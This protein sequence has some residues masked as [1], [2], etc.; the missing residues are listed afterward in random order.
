MIGLLTNSPVSDQLVHWG[1]G[2]NEPQQPEGEVEGNAD[3]PVEGSK[4]TATTVPCSQCGAELEFKPTTQN[5]R[6]SYCGHSQHIEVSADAHV[7]EYDLNDA[8]QRYLG[9]V[10]K[11]ETQG[12]REIKCQDCGADIIVEAGQKTARCD[13]CGGRR[14]IEE[15]LPPGVLQAEGLLPF[16]FKADDAVSKFRKWL[17][18]GD[19]WF[20]KLW[21]R[22]VRPRALQQ[23]ASVEDLH[24]IYVPYWTYDSKAHA[25]WTA[26]AG[27]YYYVTRSYR[28]SQGRSRTRQ[29]RRVRWVWTSGQRRDFFDDWLVC[30]SKQFHQGK[31]QGLLQQIE[32]FPTKQ[33]V[34]YDGKYLV[35]FRA[36]R[37]SL[38][39]KQG[40][41]IARTGMQS[42]IRNRCARD[43]PGD[44]YRFLDVRTSFFG[45][46][47]KLVALPVY[48]M[49]Y[50]FNNKQFNV[51]INGSTGLVKGEAPL[52]PIKVAILIAVILLI[53]G[54]IFGLVSLAGSDSPPPQQH[55]QPSLTEPQEHQDVG[56][57]PRHQL[58]VEVYDPMTD[59]DEMWYISWRFAGATG[60]EVSANVAE[61]QRLN[62]DEA[63]RISLSMLIEEESDRSHYFIAQSIENYINRTYPR[64]GNRPRVTDTRIDRIVD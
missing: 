22:L 27:Y 16:R 33:L 31:L 52:S 57:I 60:E 7:I 17:A 44:T 41:G 43:I 63:L 9:R 37:Y 36:E 48:V 49:G 8:M 58:P 30:A 25:Y 26:Q 54:G 1:D 2:V 10:P 28:D 13:Y 29:E 32:P 3:D 24:G 39:L 38:D 21:V 11:M 47:F 14:L 64:E 5:L 56:R 42:E 61:F 50:R 19:S 18:G 45:Q 40:W 12:K 46:S 34:P 62:L 23:T 53:L 59:A 35:G 55:Q 51:L 4:A 6:C 20:G 15:D